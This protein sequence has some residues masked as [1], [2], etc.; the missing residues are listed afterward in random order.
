MQK[1][2]IA[3]LGLE[4]TDLRT[5][6]RLEDRRLVIEEMRAF[7]N[8]PINISGHVDVSDLRMPVFE[9]AVTAEDAGVVNTEDATLRADA[10]LQ[11]TGRM[12]AVR[13]AGGVRTRRGG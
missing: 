6:T 13:A 8:G 10:D 7:S 4:I 12:D 2:C 5:S 9:L 1:I 3:S 11:I